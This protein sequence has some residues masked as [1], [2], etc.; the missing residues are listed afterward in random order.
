MRKGECELLLRGAGPD[1]QPADV[2]SDKDAK[3]GAM[4]LH[5]DFCTARE[6][7]RMYMHPTRTWIA[8]AHDCIP[9][10]HIRALLQFGVL[11]R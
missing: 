2:S 8:R 9:C 11:S 4:D 6:A 1:A 5:C 3:V 10:G 7:S